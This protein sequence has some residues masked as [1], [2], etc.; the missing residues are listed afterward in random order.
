MSEMM[1]AVTEGE[2]TGVEA[3]L[4]GFRVAGKTATAQKVDAATGKMSNDKFTASF[5]GFVPAE[6]PR[7]VIAVVLDEPAIAHYGSQVAAPTFRRIAEMSLRYLGVTPRATVQAPIAKIKG[8]ED[9]AE[10][11]FEALRD[12]QGEPPVHELATPS[13]PTAPG[14]VRIP[15]MKGLGVRE[16]VRTAIGLGLAPAIEGTGALSRQDPPAG[17]V[18][19]KGSSVKLVFSPPT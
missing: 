12:A 1:V 9:P 11:T 5:V 17:A 3:A 19:P 13:A 2:G 10:A 16:A 14:S 15:D 8:E 6:R 4:M 18:L 7:V